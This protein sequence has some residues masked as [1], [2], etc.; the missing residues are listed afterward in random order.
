MLQSN[1][2]PKKVQNKVFIKGLRQ[3]N[4]FKILFIDKGN[5]KIFQHLN[6]FA[7]NAPIWKSVKL[8]AHTTVQELIYKYNP[9][10][11]DK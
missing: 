2:L 4:N 1:A 8:N 7:V 11:G 10:N 3:L 9:Q 6:I 5:L